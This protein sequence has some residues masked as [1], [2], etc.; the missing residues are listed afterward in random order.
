MLLLG[1]LQ[2]LLSSGVVVESPTLSRL[3]FAP[4]PGGRTLTSSL[5]QS[6]AKPQSNGHNYSARAV[7]RRVRL[8][9]PAKLGTLGDGKR[10]CL[11]GPRKPAWHIQRRVGRM[12]MKVE[13]HASGS[14]IKSPQQRSVALLLLTLSSVH[15]HTRRVAVVV[16]LL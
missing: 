11:Y 9:P 12:K 3:N 14:R 5:P 6:P 7:Q 15:T 8:V 10:K 13:D 4:F 16:L 2:Q 1:C